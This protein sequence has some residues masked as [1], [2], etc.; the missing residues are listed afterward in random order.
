MPADAFVI[1][2]LAGATLA[3]VAII[4]VALSL[5]G[6]A[7]VTWRHSQR[8]AGVASPQADEVPAPEVPAPS[9]ESL[10]QPEV[11]RSFTWYRTRTQLSGK[12]ISD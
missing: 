2:V 11:V 12:C 4:I 1:G 8:L 10:Q 9:M 6:R 3:T 7:A 5:F